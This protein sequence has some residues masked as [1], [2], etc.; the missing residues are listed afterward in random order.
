MSLIC[1][2][3]EILFVF[4]SKRPSDLIIKFGSDQNDEV[5]EIITHPNF[6]KSIETL[7][8]NIVSY[9]ENSFLT[10]L[11]LYFIQK[12]LLLLEHE[13]YD[14]DLPCIIKNNID[15]GHCHV[16]SWGN[17]KN[18]EN[19]MKIDNVE[20]FTKGECYTSHL[21]SGKKH[22]KYVNKGNSNICV[23]SAN[24]Y[25]LDIV[26]LFYEINV[27]KLFINI[28]IFNRT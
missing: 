6:F 8:D 16:F 15:N 4:H 17:H 11:E 26:R 2:R 12:A 3:L 24:H 21:I 9:F 10:M 20:V 5:K 14:G 28:W 22:E 18:Y 23:G 1:S 7:Q 13:I 25:E 27:R 19:S